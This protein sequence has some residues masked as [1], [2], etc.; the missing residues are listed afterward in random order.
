MT[1]SNVPAFTKGILVALGV[2]LSAVLVLLIRGWG[3]TALPGAGGVNG[4]PARDRS[5]ATAAPERIQQQNA[6]M[7]P[8][9]PMREAPVPEGRPRASGENERARLAAELG[10]VDYG[11][12]NSIEKQAVAARLKKEFEGA[13]KDISALDESKDS[14]KMHRLLVDILKYQ[15]AMKMMESDGYLTTD[16]V[17]IPKTM[18]TDM[19]PMILFNAATVDSRPVG[20]LFPIRVTPGSE[21]ELAVRMRQ[22]AADVRID[23]VILTFNAQP[24]DVRTQRIGEMVRAQDAINAA[25]SARSR[26]EISEHVMGLR[27]ASF[28]NMQPPNGTVIDR[29]AMKLRRP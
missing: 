19:N 20:V 11:V 26:G 25:V 18:P 29:A 3:S 23:L 15:E 21:L 9:K 28:L 8:Q 13:F 6:V 22:D 5:A 10:L 4:D 12:L 2:I 14:E 17:A 24:L 16:P 1:N 27:T 7:D